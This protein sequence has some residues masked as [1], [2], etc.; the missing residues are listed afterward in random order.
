MDDITEVKVLY[1]P[2][3]D[4]CG[5]MAVYDG[6]TKYGPWAYMC[7]CCFQTAGKGLGLGK[8][9]RLVQA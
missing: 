2:K 1:I 6:K 3:C 7:E 8:G 5:D 4:L 9:Q